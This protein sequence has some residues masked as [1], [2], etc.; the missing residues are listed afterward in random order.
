MSQKQLNP[1]NEFGPGQ[2]KPASGNAGARSMAKK[3]EAVLEHVRLR[4]LPTKKAKLLALADAIEAAELAKEGIGFNMR[5]YYSTGN[6]RVKDQ[7]GHRCGTVACIAG[8][9]SLLDDEHITDVGAI[10][11]RAQDILEL[12]DDEASCLFTGA[13][14]DNCELQTITTKCV[15][16]AIRDFANTGVITWMGFDKKGRKIR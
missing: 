14:S 1:N 12:D 5:W 4:D 3:A 15:V 8:W 7:T 16:A 11:R 9:A 2:A 13:F 6:A 10:R